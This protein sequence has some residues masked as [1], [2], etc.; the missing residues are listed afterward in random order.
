MYPVR[1]AHYILTKREQKTE[2]ADTVIFLF[3]TF[4]YTRKFV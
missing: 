4:V 3:V 1:M 2:L